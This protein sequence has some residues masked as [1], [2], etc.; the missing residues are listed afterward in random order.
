MPYLPVPLSLSLEL[1]S[2]VSHVLAINVSTLPTMLVRHYPYLLSHINPS[3]L[4]IHGM[5]KTTAV[6]T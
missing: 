3:L 6:F 2:E 5:A 4:L 1:Y